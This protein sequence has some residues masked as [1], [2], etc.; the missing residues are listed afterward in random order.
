[1][2]INSVVEAQRKYFESGATR[3]TELR[4]E[5]LKKLL[6]KLLLQKQILKSMLLQQVQLSKELSLHLKLLL[7]N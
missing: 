4:I 6:L 2:N 5:M 7:I 1:M 3:S